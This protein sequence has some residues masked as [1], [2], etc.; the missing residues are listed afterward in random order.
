MKQERLLKVIFSP[1][2]SEKA[3]IG[4]E[5]RGEYVFEVAP[6]A[7]KP[8]VKEAV[9]LL[10]KTEVKAVRI[11]NVKTKPK[12]FGAILGRSKAWKKAYVTLKA[13]QQID[14]VGGQA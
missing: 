13:G 9:E 14:F 12:R 3:A 6:T 5:K 11:V 8:E 2:M 7:T 10:F 1:H 4:T